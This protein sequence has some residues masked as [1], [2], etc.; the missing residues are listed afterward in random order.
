MLSCYNSL[1]ATGICLHVQVL[2]S[3]VLIAY[4]FGS[5][6]EIAEWGLPDHDKYRPCEWIMDSRYNY[7]LRPYSNCLLVVV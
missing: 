7:G 5:K 4:L 2:C 1:T 6:V 3:A